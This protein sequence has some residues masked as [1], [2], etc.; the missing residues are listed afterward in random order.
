MAA[1]YNKDGSIDLVDET[2]KRRTLHIAAGAK[3]IQE[4]AIAQFFAPNVVADAA[5]VQDALVAV[6]K[7]D[8]P[9]LAKILIDKGVLTAADFLPTN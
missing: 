9:A 1:T 3:D 2:D 6:S 8:A 7:L 5:K 4:G